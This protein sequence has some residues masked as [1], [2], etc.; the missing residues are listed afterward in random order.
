MGDGN[1][2]STAIDSLAGDKKIDFIKMDIEGY[3]SQALHGAKRTLE[4]NDVKLDICVYHNV[5][6]EEEIKK[7]LEEYGYYTE[8]SE[9]YMVFITEQFWEKEVI[10][11]K[12]VKGLIRGRKRE[13]ERR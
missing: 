12:F 10:C 7:L 11:P 13:C 9:G 5:N 8:T 4:Q 3:E 6:D 1:G 2:G